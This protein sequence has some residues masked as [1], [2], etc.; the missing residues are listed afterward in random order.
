[1]A[2]QNCGWYGRGYLPHHDSTSHYQFIT[3]RLFDSI[4]NEVLKDL[5]I[6]K[7][8]LDPNI[9]SSELLKLIDSYLDKG[10]GSC[11]LRHPQMAKVLQDTFIKFDNDKYLLLAWCI[12][13]NHVHIL[14]KPNSDLHKIVQSWKSYTGRWGLQNWLN[15]SLSPKPKKFWQWDYWDHYIRNEKHFLNTIEYI[16]NNPVKANLV[17]KPDAWQWSSAYRQ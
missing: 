6:K 4:P 10:I 16:H 15:L 17:A 9:A 7:A 2:Q 12:M 3:F 14:I 8:D 1:M 5:Q 11:V 13:P